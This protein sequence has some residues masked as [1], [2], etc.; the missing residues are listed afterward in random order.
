[1]VLGMPVMDQDHYMAK[2]VPDNDSAACT[3]WAAFV[4]KRSSQWGISKIINE[5]L[6]TAGRAPNQMLHNL[7]TKG[8]SLPHAKP[9]QIYDCVTPLAW[10]LFG[11]DAYIGRGSFLKEAVI[12]FCCII[13]TLSW[14]QYHK[15][16]T[17][18]VHLM[19]S[20]CDVVM[21]HRKE[22]PKN[23]RDILLGL[24]SKDDIQAITHALLVSIEDLNGA[25]S[26]E[27]VEL[28]LDAPI[29]PDWKE[30]VESGTGEDASGAWCGCVS[31]TIAGQTLNT[32]D[33]NVPDLSHMIICPINLKQQF[34][35]CMVDRIVHSQQATIMPTDNPC[36]SNIIMDKDLYI[37]GQWMGIPG[38]DNHNEFL[39][40]NKEINRTNHQD[41]KPL[42]EAGIEGSIISSIFIGIHNQNTPDLLSPEITHEWMVKI[43]DKLCG[44]CW[45][46]AV[47]LEAIFRTYPQAV[48]NFFKE[49][50]I[51]STNTRKPVPHVTP[52][53]MCANTLMLINFYIKF[54]C[55]MLHPML[56]LKNSGHWKKPLSLTH[57][58][59]EKMIKLDILAQVIHHHLDSN[60]CVPLMMT[61]DG[62]TL[63]LAPNSLQDMS[64]YGEDDKVIIYSTQ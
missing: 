8:R 6:E 40:L 61:E 51:V 3:A 45:Y 46:Q 19:D 43:Y 59:K 53:V 55:L 64:D 33:R 37:M 36:N 60:G 27:H 14:N 48:N 50:P 23:L 17:H 34:L 20:L 31:L 18:D 1:M 63:T 24:A 47:Q 5:V 16:V 13:L 9:M 54:Q 42:H 4:S 29:E 28:N 39:E 58:Q 52:N 10:K 62:Q 32:L 56:N 38:F 22:L 30:G 35:Q 15:G 26:V 2:C 21:E 57:W 7:G 11:D 41:S 25:E 12:K 44:P 49:N